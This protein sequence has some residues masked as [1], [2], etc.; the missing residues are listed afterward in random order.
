MLG[1][2][3]RPAAWSVDNAGDLR[4]FFDTPLGERLL[5]RLCQVAPSAGDVVASP[6][7]SSDFKLGQLD[8]WEQA[9][10]ML[11]YLSHVESADGT[12]TSTP[13]GDP[14]YPPLEDDKAWPAPESIV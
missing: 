5:G 1:S 9:L 10:T 4:E 7:G 11:R 12:A 8:G 14:E 13:T 3:L 2:S 6:R